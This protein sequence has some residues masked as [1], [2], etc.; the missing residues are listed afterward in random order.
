VTAPWAEPDAETYTVE[1]AALGGPVDPADEHRTMYANVIS[2]G[3]NIRRPIVPAEFRNPDQRREMVKLA[4]GTAGYTVAFHASRTPKYAAKVLLWSPVG[5]F[6][7]AWRVTHWALDL[8][9][10]GIRQNAAS[11]NDVDGY[12]RLASQRDRRAGFRGPVALVGLVLL[13]VVVLLLRFLAPWW[14][15]YGSLAAALVTLAWIGRPADRPITDRVTLGERFVKLTA[16]QVR[17][18]LCA[19]GISKIKEPGDVTF[20]EPGIHRDGPGW[21]ARVNL[22]AG[23]E[24]VEVLE[25][26][27]RLSS[28]LRLPVDQVWPAAGPEHAGQLDLW[29]GYLPASRM[30]QPRWS[31]ASPTA[32]TSVFEPFEFGTDQRQR[33]VTTSLFEQNFLI[34]GRPGSGKSYAGRTIVTGAALDPLVE[35]KICEYKGSGDFID[36]AP[37]CSTYVCG[38]SD[39]DFADGL[40]VLLWGLAEAERRGKLIRAAKERG[41]APQGKVTPELAARPGSG[42]HPVMIVIDEAHE[43]FGDSEVGKQAGSAAE[44]LVKRGRAFGITVVIITQIPDANS[45][46]PGITRNV[47][48][49]WCLA[50]PDQVANDQI[51]GTGAYKRGV[52]GTV[53]RPKLDAGWGVIVGLAEPVSVRAQFPTPEVTKAIV[54]RAAALR[55]GVVGTAVDPAEIRDVLADVLHVFAHLGR[56]GLHW[57]ELPALLAE[58]HGDTYA[59]HTSESLSALL[60]ALDVP[61]V[62]VKIDGRVAKGCRRPEV[63]A[64]IQRR[65]ITS[66]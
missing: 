34:G 6:R 63:E 36:L 47:G 10:H 65:E 16:E 37:L 61:S 44:R 21:L 14:A 52:T 58:A 55:G 38:L 40:G 59:S 35:L 56:R 1:P 11:R 28:A 42:L 41:E 33:P 27:G 20:P 48:V 12:L 25:R 29:V 15:Q 5:L 45:L 13:V 26:R 23:V 8:E 4:A 19:L 57:A 43:L 54:E 49:R 66:D 22:P 64:A 17:N 60:R 51:L 32:R 62:D 18:A 50:V 39:Q 24:A 31:L 2:H 9:S 30:G 53:Y 7:G 3:D 46:P